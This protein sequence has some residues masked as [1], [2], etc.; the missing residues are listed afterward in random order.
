MILIYGMDFLIEGACIMPDKSDQEK[1]SELKNLLLECYV[2]LQRCN[3]IIG[4][5]VKDEFL[6]KVQ[7]TIE[8]I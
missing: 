2:E 6:E 5:Q 7:L 1:I 3:K 4:Y 8:N